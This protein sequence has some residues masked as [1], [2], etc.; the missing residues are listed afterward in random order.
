METALTEAT[1]AHGISIT[2]NTPRR[3]MLRSLQR[4]TA[5]PPS[6]VAVAKATYARDTKWAPTVA[7]PGA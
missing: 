1:S 5:C 4:S 7:A 6:Q 3:S 2:E